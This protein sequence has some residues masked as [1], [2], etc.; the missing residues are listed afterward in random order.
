MKGSCACGAVAY[1]VLKLAGPIG[2]CHCR[3]CRKTHAAAFNTAAAVAREDFRWL[4]GDGARRRYESS[5]GKYRHF[6]GDCGAHLMAERPELPN[7]VIRVA[8]LDDDPGQRPERSI[9]ASHR[10]PWLAAEG[11]PSYEEWPT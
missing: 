4:R 1:E 11:L 3:T 10:L 7:V 2:H 5:P 8:S 9:W 6:C